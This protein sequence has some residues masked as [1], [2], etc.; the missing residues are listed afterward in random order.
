MA[1]ARVLG[2]G[3]VGGLLGLGLQGGAAAL[4]KGPRGRLGVRVRGRGRRAQHGFGCRIPVEIEL[5]SGAVAARA[6][7]G[8]ARASEAELQGASGPARHWRRP[9]AAAEHSAGPGA[10]SRGGREGEDGSDERDPPVGD[11]GGEGA[12]GPARARDW[13]GGGR[14][15]R[16]KEKG[17]RAGL[18]SWAENG[19]FFSFL[20]TKQTNSIQ[21][22]TQG[23]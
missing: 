23:I 21:F 5:E 6:G 13:A 1:E 17:K 4:F 9:T 15:G 18:R 16:G 3:E 8:S 11:T 20:K 12:D 7:S 2:A 10:E 22:Q 19:I 14:L